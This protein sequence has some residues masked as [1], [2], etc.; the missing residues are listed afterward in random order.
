MLCSL[1]GEPQRKLW[2]LSAL[3]TKGNGDATSRAQ[4]DTAW[5]SD[6]KN[7][8]TNLSAFEYFSSALQV[9]LRESPWSTRAI[10]HI[11]RV[12]K[13]RYVEQI[14]GKTNKILIA[15]SLKMD[16]GKELATGNLVELDR[17]IVFKPLAQIQ[18]SAQSALETRRRMSQRDAAALF[19]QL[20]E[21]SQSLEPGSRSHRHG[22]RLRKFCTIVRGWLW[23]QEY[24]AQDTFFN[25]Q[26]A[27]AKGHRV[28]EELKKDCHVIGKDRPGVLKD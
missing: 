13:R 3:M 11:L 1:A 2:W 17:R 8:K 21:I 16:S 18:S 24:V 10:S 15:E 4:H 26:V 19:F 25:S 14:E 28:F 12:Q 27:I 6:A 9:L 22:W 23:S 5:L 20:M 7:M